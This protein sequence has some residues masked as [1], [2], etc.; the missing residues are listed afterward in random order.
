M[1]SSFVKIALLTYSTR[2][3][4]G[5]VH[6][7]Y[8]ADALKKKG[9]DV[10]VFALGPPNEFYR[11]FEV[12]HE[13]FP[14]EA[15]EN[16]PLRARV[17]R[18]TDVYLDKLRTRSDYDVYHAQDCISGNAIE[19]L[20]DEG[21]LKNTARTV[22]H[23]ERYSDE[24][25]NECQA[26]AIVRAPHRIVVSRYWQRYL[27]RRF[28][29]DSEVIYNGLD[30]E[31]FSPS[32]DG[33]KLKDELSLGNKFVYLSVGGIEPRKGSLH[34]LNAFR[35]VAQSSPNARL[36]VVC[37]KGIVRHDPYQR[38]FAKALDCS[39]LGEKVT[40]LEN[41][42]DERMPALYRAS[43]AFVFPSVL[44]GWGL[45]ALEAMSCGIPV[46]AFDLPTMRELLNRENA[47]LVEPR[48]EEMLAHAMLKLSNDRSLWQRLA[49]RGREC[50]SRYSWDATA[51]AMIRYYEEHFK[52]SL[53][54]SPH[55]LATPLGPMQL[56]K[57]PCPL[58]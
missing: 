49:E 5:V 30:K 42:Q 16:E 23:V 19:V 18:L 10:K 54:T 46:V 7:T 22:H 39:G 43:D 38:K 55:P 21:V 40:L 58:R 29:V 32:I 24:K 44:E 15:L 20:R 36:V 52:K 37:T 17:K 34:L 2:S 50:A 33:T 13:I 51:D 14:T 56:A 11:K 47:M 35:K 26:R 9:H 6:T 8:L 27:K 48:N 3:R 1:H 41:F 31:R 57:P 45:A 12:A 25:V 53:S 4:G 28:G